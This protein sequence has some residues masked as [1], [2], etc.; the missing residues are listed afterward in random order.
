MG[1]CEQVGIAAHLEG[2]GACTSQACVRVCRPDSSDSSGRVLLHSA[3]ASAAAARAMPTAMN[4]RAVHNPLPLLLPL[5]LRLPTCAM[6]AVWPG[7]L[8]SVLMV[9]MARATE[10]AYISRTCRWRGGEG[11]A[12]KH[13]WKL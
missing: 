6:K 12:A 9:F 7:G 11:V 4:Q 8:S 3:A 1:S 2:E 5:L 10:K 13:V